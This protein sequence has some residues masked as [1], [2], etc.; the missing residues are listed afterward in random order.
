MLQ[1]SENKHNSMR[2]IIFSLAVALT[3]I[4]TYA[5]NWAPVGENIRSEWAEQV[6]PSNPLPAYPRPQMFR[7]DW[8]NLNGLWNYA[9]TEASS[10]EFKADGQILVPFA[11]ESSLSG[12][13]KRITKNDALWY[14]REF[15][16]PKK[17]KGKNILLHFGAVDWQAEVYV[18]GSLV[19]GHKGGFDPFSFDITPY[20]NKSGKQ[21]LTVK[22][23]DATDN[24]FQPRGKQC[25]INRGIWYTP[26]SGIWQTVWLEPV[27]PTHI[28]NYY[29]VSDIDNATMTFEVAALTVDGDVIKVAVLEG[30]EGYS[31]EA[32][33]TSILA[34]AEIVDGKAVVNIPDMKT[35]S[36]DSPYLYGVKVSV[37]R[38]GKVID[39]VDGY[40]AM[41]K[42][43]V[44][45][46]KSPNK[47]RRMALNNEILFQFGPLD[48][49][50]WPDGL[51]TAPTDEALE[52]DVIKTKELG[53]NMIRK[54]IKVEPARWYYFCDLHGLVVWQDMPSIGDH[55]KKQMPARDPEIVAAISNNWS[56]DSGVGGTYC[57]IPQEWKDNFYNEWTNIINAFKNFQCIVVWVPFNEAWGQFDTPAAV[58]LT[59][60]LDPTRLI[61]CS[62]GGN[63][64]FSEGVEG[65]GDILD[66]HH[67]SCPAMN[68]FDRKFV[69]VVGEYGGLGLPI[70]GHT[71]TIEEKWGYGGN[72]KDAEDVMAR[73]ER[74][75]N[76]LKI[77]VKTGCAAAVYTQTTDVEGEVN[78][79]ITYD[80]KV[81]KV[82]VPRISDVNKS[83]I[84][85]INNL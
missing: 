6:D 77:F 62:S 9:I 19:G 57:N 80:R 1:E 30:G 72:K 56:S 4:A 11:L 44:V 45:K 58:K 27:A 66:V 32:P 3:A 54:H 46:D 34:E 59:R 21:T 31:A 52:F 22:V 83:L 20:L 61:N 65:F 17:W 18:N 49:G 42:I 23:Q 67:Y 40:T 24:S 73:Y 48:Q 76:M 84:E 28:E 35:W 36:P 39:S 14:E 50:W 26:V 75:V 82:D 69:N 29:I 25:F 74:Y 47:Y 43:S 2:K 37:E 33:S 60:N 79:L 41:R 53:Y 38:K 10:E 63:Y 85:S 64:D 68:F 78:G 7:A 81:V 70:E 12:V 15:T 55:D 5:Q 71:W 8:M 13:G 16:I 51:Y